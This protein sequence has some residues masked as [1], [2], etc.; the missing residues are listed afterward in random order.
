LVD[1]ELELIALLELG[2]FGLLDGKKR[3]CADDCGKNE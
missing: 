2:G 3:N 1:L